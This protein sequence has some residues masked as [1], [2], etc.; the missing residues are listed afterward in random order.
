M[1]IVAPTLLQNPR[2]PVLVTHMIDASPL[3]FTQSFN[4]LKISYPFTW[5][6]QSFPVSLSL[7]QIRICFKGLRWICCMNSGGLI[8]F[9]IV[10]DHWT[11]K[12]WTSPPK[13]F[14]S[15]L[16]LKSEKENTQNCQIK[17]FD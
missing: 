5:E 15:I 11:K 12:H 14:K 10:S 4:S 13:L 3:A 6:Q 7:V 17:S 8:W 1:T 16:L 2:H 9:I